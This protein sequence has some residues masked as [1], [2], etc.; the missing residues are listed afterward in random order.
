MKIELRNERVVVKGHFHE[1]GS[2]LAGTAEGFCDGFEVE[3]LLESGAPETTLQQ[4][5]RM[6]RRMCFTEK[7]LQGETPLV[8]S[9]RLNGHPLSLPD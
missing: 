7:A 1:Q 6:A 9:A 4:L 5:V 3:V 8:V 2:V